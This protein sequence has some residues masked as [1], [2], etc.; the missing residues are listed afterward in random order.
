M[1]QTPNEL[2]KRL[3]FWGLPYNR[4]VRYSIQCRLRDVFGLTLEE[5]D[6]LFASNNYLDVMELKYMLYFD[7]YTSA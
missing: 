6:S 1:M 2:K 5:I 3:E 7:S 4:V